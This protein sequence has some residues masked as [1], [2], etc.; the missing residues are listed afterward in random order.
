M[1]Q[2]KSRRLES[3]ILS[4]RVREDETEVDVYDMTVRIQKNVPVMPA[5]Q[6]SKLF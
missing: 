6:N 5:S 3:E 4:G 1:S 2:L